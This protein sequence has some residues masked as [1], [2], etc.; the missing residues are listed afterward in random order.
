MK[1]RDPYPLKSRCMAAVP[2]I[3]DVVY[4]TISARRLGD[5]ESYD[6]T[7]DDG[8]VHPNLPRNALTLI[9]GNVRKLWGSRHESAVPSNG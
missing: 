2:F 9:G 5:Y 4:G 1:E 6:V 8:K 7:G 3:N